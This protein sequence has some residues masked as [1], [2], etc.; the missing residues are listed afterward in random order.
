[1]SGGGRC[2]V[3]QGAT[4]CNRRKRGRS[5]QAYCQAATYNGLPSYYQYFSDSS[6]AGGFEQADY[7]PY[8]R[9]FS[10]RLCTE[11]SHAP[12]SN[13]QGQ[14][15]SANSMCYESTLRQ[16]I[17]GYVVASLHC[18]SCEGM[19]TALATGLPHPTRWWAATR[20]SAC[21]LLC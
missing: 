9:G 15:Y 7:C 6:L 5:A 18:G 17:G 16:S 4:A 20:R 13:Y 10:N 3:S 12:S 14:G 1:M 8:R 19:P 11:P 2:D 21:H